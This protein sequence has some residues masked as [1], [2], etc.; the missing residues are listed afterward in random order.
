MTRAS[1]VVRLGGNPDTTSA[2]DSVGISWMRAIAAF[3]ERLGNLRQDDLR[4]ES[5]LFCKSSMY[6]QSGDRLQPVAALVLRRD[7]TA[8]RGLTTKLR[9]D[10]HLVHLTA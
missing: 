3:H 9:R 2:I 8:L 4:D 6:R 1:L 10:I 7:N 5:C